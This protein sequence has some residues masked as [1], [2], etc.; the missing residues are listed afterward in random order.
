MSLAPAPLVELTRSGVREGVHAGHAVIVGADG[1]IVRAWGDPGALI[2]PRSANKPFQAR[3][4]VELGLDL[5]EHLLALAAAS[6]GGEDFHC[7]GT[8]M[9]LAGAGLDETALQC[10]PDL[11]LDA[12]ERDMWVCAGRAP[13][14]VAWNC[15]GKHA[16]ML[17]TCVLQG[18]STD[19]YLDPTHPLQQAITTT[20]E[21]LTGEPVWTIA[22]DGCGAPLH[23]TS[24]VGLARAMS[25]MVQAPDGSSSARVVAAMRAW[26]EWVGG[27][28]LD[29]T[30]FM[31]A[32]PGLVAKNGAEG[33]YVAALPDGTGLALKITDGADRARIVAFADLLVQAGVATDELADL[34]TQ[35]VTGGGAVVG[36]VR[37][38]LGGA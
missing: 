8:R 21:E 10:P 38:L 24:V 3:A 2:L 4:M 5:P 9:I 15:S 7:A 37:G 35:P 22:V 27:T 33:V 25:R 20:I 30:A 14:R 12:A 13:S 32:V 28:R 6:H 36:Q 11:P 23:G 34:L 18:W 1:T 26:P 19:D 29:A 17:A 31:Q 16:A